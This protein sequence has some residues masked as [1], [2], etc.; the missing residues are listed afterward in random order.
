MQGVDRCDP[1]L[2][3]VVASSQDTAKVHKVSVDIVL[4]DTLRQ[5]GD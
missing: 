3:Y 4:G 1:T 5:L 2:D